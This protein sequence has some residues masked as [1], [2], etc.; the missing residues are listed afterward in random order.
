MGSDIFWENLRRW[1]DSFLAF[2]QG[3]GGH[4]SW[5]CGG[6]Q[7]GWWVQKGLMWG[8]CNPTAAWAWA[9]GMTL[10][11]EGVCLHVSCSMWLPSSHLSYLLHRGEV[12]D[13][14]LASLGRSE[15]VEGAWPSYP[16][17]VCRTWGHEGPA[18]IHVVIFL[19]SSGGKW[20]PLVRSFT[21]VASAFMHTLVYMSHCFHVL[22]QCL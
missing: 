11:S 12:W 9:Q 14:I 15:N 8:P 4:I 21:V 17:S 10:H 22:Y 5:L 3:G 18:E 7:C 1:V 2:W 13:G 19:L 20:S 6:F 16:P